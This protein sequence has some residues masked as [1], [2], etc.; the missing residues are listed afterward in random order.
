MRLFI[1]RGA[2]RW[3]QCWREV[4]DG[5]MVTHTV[6]VIGARQGAG[7]GVK[8]FHRIVVSP[9]KST[10]LFLCWL[11]GWNPL[12]ALPGNLGLERQLAVCHGLGKGWR[13]ASPRLPPLPGGRAGPLLGFPVAN[14][15]KS[16]ASKSVNSGTLA[17][18]AQPKS[19]KNRAFPN[20]P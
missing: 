2:V 5:Q 11:I 17:R 4:V 13:L 12:S 3:K 19:L 9:C 15:V 6:N 20:P 8:L 18:P 7:W 10:G 16:G 14:R 1:Y